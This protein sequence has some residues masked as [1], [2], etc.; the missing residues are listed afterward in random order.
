M[1][2]RQHN[3]MLYYTAQGMFMSTSIAVKRL[4]RLQCCCAL[5]H[6]LASQAYQTQPGVTRSLAG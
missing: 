2:M 5:E 1:L 4:H 3:S 6:A